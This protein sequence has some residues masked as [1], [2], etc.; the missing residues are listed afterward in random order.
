MLCYVHMYICTWYALCVRA[1]LCARHV[2]CAAVTARRFPLYPPSPADRARAYVYYYYQLE[3]LMEKCFGDLQFL[4]DEL[5]VVVPPV[6]EG[7]RDTRPLHY[8]TYVFTSY[9]RTEFY[10]PF[11]RATICVSWM[12]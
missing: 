6:P 2:S 1:A 8:F 4:L 12:T 10:S 9:V 5:E 11:C 3:R 7:E